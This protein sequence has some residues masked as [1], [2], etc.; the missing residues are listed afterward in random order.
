MQCFGGIVFS[1]ATFFILMFWWDIVV[2]FFCGYLFLNEL[3]YIS[4]ASSIHN[5]AE[6]DSVHAIIL[7]GTHMAQKGLFFAFQITRM[8]F[9]IPLCFLVM[10]Q[11][12]VTCLSLPCFRAKWGSSLKSQIS[13]GHLQKLCDISFITQLFS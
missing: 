9:E 5:L 6:V 1:I 4:Q 11:G 12:H 10:H 2:F 13:V 8:L 7:S 3:L